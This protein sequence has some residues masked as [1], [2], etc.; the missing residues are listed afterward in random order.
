VDAIEVAW[1]ELRGLEESLGVLQHRSQVLRSSILATA[2][3]GGLVA[4]DPIDEPASSLLQRM[5]DGG[6][7]P[8]A[9]NSSSRRQR[10]SEANA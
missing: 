7:T 8:K 3:S 5:A 2:F 6:A 4:Q 10:G 9:G 1:A